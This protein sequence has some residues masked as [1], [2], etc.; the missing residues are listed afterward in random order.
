MKYAKLVFPKKKVN[1]ELYVC[2]Y[3]SHQ[4]NACGEFGP[5]KRGYYLFHFIKSGKGVYYVDGKSFKLS[6]NQGFIIRPNEETYYRA[7]ERTPWEYEFVA[8]NGIL[9]EELVGS[10][11]WEDGYVVKPEN[12]ARIRRIMNSMVKIKDDELNK[13]GGGNYQLI[14]ELYLLFAELIKN[15]GCAVYAEENERK[16]VLNKA[17]DYIKEH[18]FE[19]LEVENVAKYVNMHRSNLFRLFKEELNVSVWQYVQNFRM[20]MAANLL[21]NTDLPVYE[22]ANRVGMPDYPHFCRQFKSFFLETPK[23]FRKNFTGGQSYDKKAKTL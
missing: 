10:V 6:K 21:C 8:F 22:V 4:V 12:Y 16:V 15:G 17:I 14:G 20:D 9:A 18:Y 13:S 23:N 19:E 1:N 11:A 7:D 3:G 5:A 2:H